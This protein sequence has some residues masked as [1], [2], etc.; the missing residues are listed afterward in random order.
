MGSRPLEK[1]LEI[2]IGVELCCSEKSQDEKKELGGDKFDSVEANSQTDVK[3][4]FHTG[5][6]SAG[7]MF[8]CAAY[9]IWLRDVS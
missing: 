9:D 6:G 2:W 5:R 3:S 1:A 7:Q 4:S 8:W